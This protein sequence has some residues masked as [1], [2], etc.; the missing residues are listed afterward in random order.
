MASEGEE[1]LYVVERAERSG[2]NWMPE[3]ALSSEDIRC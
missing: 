1:G 2:M 3:R